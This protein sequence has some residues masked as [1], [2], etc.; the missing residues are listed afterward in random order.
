MNEGNLNAA[1]LIDHSSTDLAVSANNEMAFYLFE[2]DFVD[3]GFPDLRPMPA[4]DRDRDPL[5]NPDL[6]R[7]NSHKDE[8]GKKLRSVVHAMVIDGVRIQYPKSRILPSQVLQPHVHPNAQ[9]SESRQE[10]EGESQAAN[11]E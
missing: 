1:Q 11:E 9:N 7:K 3:H 2:A 10:Q 6:E 5:C 8:Q 4:E